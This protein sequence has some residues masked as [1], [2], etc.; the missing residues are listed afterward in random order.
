MIEEVPPICRSMLR[1]PAFCSSAILLMLLA[2]RATLSSSSMPGKAFGKPVSNSLRNSAL[3]GME[4]TTR[5]S[6]LAAAYTFSHSLLCAEIETEVSEE[7][8]IDSDRTPDNLPIDPPSFCSRRRI[9]E[10]RHR[11]RHAR[12]LNRRF[13]VDANL[14]IFIFVFD[15]RSTLARAGAHAF[16]V[17][18]APAAEEKIAR[19]AA[20]AKRQLARLLLAGIEMLVEPAARR[21]QNAAF[22]PVDAHDLVGVA[23]MIGSQSSF[24]R[25]H[26]RVPL[27]AENQQN[28]AALMKMRFVVTA[29][30]PLGDMPD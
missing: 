30:R 22:A 4:T 1:T 8:A 18:G 16:F 17:D 10:L 2:P 24:L 14:R 11:H 6:F 28:R 12:L 21:T 9:V 15:H 26:Q 13:K 5:A 7:T 29:H 23:V 25:P 27:R 20:V 19:L 3:V